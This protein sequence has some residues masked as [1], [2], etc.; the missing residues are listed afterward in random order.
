RSSACRIDLEKV[1][2]A[3]VSIGIKDDA[4]SVVGLRSS[5]AAHCF[6]APHGVNGD[7]TRIGVLA[8]KAKID[9]V[10]RD[11]YANLR[12]VR[13]RL[14]RFRRLLRELQ[15]RRVTPHRF[16]QSAIE[17]DRS[18]R[19]DNRF[20]T[21]AVAR[22]GVSQTRRCQNHAEVPNTLLLPANSRNLQPIISGATE[23]A[24]VD[25][26]QVSRTESLM[27]PSRHYR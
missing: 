23:S 7:V 16:I 24:L 4:D 20:D 11:N 26:K 2:G 15:H 1:A 9:A 3:A 13:R 17:H 8:L 12:F 25:Q 18:R 6:I 19:A 27:S 22:S 10:A 5:T 21:R 14:S